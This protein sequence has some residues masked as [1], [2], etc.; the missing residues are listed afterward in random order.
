MLYFYAIAPTTSAIKKVGPSIKTRVHPTI[1]ER[2][3]KITVETEA[4]RSPRTIVV[5]NAAGQ[6]VWK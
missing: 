6:T 2:N 5:S 4:S 3:Q 1:A